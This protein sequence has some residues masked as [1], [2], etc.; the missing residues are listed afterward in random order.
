MGLDSIELSVIREFAEDMPGGFFI[1][2]ADGIEELIYVNQAMIRIFGCETEEEF[3]KLTGNTFPG[4]V[5]PQDIEKIEASIEQQVKSDDQKFDYVE[6]RIIKKDGAVRWIEDYGRLVS[7]RE[8][9]DIYCVFAMDGTERQKG[10]MEELERINSELLNVYTR[11]NQ[12]KQALVA[13]AVSYLEVDLSKDEF[14]TT[15]MQVLDG[16]SVDMYE[17]CGMPHFDCFSEFISYM[18]VKVDENMRGDYLAFFNV[19]RL[20]QCYEEGD[21]WQTMDVWTTDFS[22]KRCMYRYHAYLGQSDVTGDVIALFMAKDVTDRAEN[23]DLWQHI[24]KKAWKDG[25]TPNSD[26]LYKVFETE[27][28]CDLMDV[29]SEVDGLITPRLRRKQQHFLVDYRGVRHFEVFMKA[30]YLKEI[31]AQLLDNASKFTQAHGDISVVITENTCDEELCSEFLCVV[32]D[33]GCGIGKEFLENMFHPFERERNTRECGGF[34]RGLG[35]T[36]IQELVNRL[37]GR[38]SVE[39]QK[40][41][42]TTVT[43]AMIARWKESKND[44]EK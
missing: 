1:Y 29:I 33:N 30:E 21:W 41:E 10:R 6:Y 40:G 18:S 16:Q 44:D 13:D 28:T 22:G 17:F 43:V 8:Y 14:I 32:Q 9:G 19:S 37:N 34:G 42:G 35:L 12:Y 36:V 27:E 31:L 15:A 39:S 3:R 4:M 25:V 5:H 26:I 11:E 2:H 23:Q 24:L 38:I 7:T 20:A